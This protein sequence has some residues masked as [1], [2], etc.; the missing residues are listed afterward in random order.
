[1][2]TLLKLR[3]LGKVARCYLVPSG[4]ENLRDFPDDPEPGYG[5]YEENSLQIY[6]AEG[7]VLDQEQDT[8]LHELWHLIDDLLEVGLSEKQIVKLTTAWLA[9]L[10]ENPKLITYLKRR[11]RDG[12]TEG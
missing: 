1:M 3:V 8:L 5:R 2:K 12:S 11:P 7:Q 10:K 6:V 4:H 9:V